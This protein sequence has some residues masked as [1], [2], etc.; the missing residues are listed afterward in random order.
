MRIHFAWGAGTRCGRRFVDRLYTY[1]RIEDITCGSCIRLITLDRIYDAETIAKMGG[2][3]F[4]QM[5]RWAAKANAGR[6]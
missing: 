6:A 3:E 2:E 4:L 1:S 5:K